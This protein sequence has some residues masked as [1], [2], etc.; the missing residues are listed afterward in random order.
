Q[1]ISK[2]SEEFYNQFSEARTQFQSAMEKVL[3]QLGPYLDLGPSE[4]GEP[5]TSS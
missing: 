2:S 3:S 4:T 5:P 1:E